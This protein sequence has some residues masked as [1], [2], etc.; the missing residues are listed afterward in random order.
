L[1]TVRSSEVIGR[2]IKGFFENYSQPYRFVNDDLITVLTMPLLDGLI[3]MKNVTFFDLLFV[4]K[5]VEH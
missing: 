1:E 2:S 5:S 4:G 3:A